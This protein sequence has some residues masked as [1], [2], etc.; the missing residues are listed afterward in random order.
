MIFGGHFSSSCL[1]NLLMHHFAFVPA[2]VSAAT[3]LH[4]TNNIGA[5]N[6]DAAHHVKDMKILINIKR[7]PSLHLFFVFF[8]G[9]GL[10]L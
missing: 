9:L 2:V 5:S 1:S 8:K 7:G 6:I 10:Y 3:E 4:V